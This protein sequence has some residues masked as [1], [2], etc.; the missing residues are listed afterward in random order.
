MC[1]AIDLS[2]LKVLYSSNINIYVVNFMCSIVKKVC[3]KFTKGNGYFLAKIY[4]TEV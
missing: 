1:G 2:N 4:V 3:Q